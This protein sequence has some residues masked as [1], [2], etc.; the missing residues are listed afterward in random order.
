MTM[1]LLKA[2]NDYVNEDI[3]NSNLKIYRYSSSFCFSEA[4]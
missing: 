1:E 2:M 3:A 4:S